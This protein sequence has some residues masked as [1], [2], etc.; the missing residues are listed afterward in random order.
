MNTD[1]IKYSVLLPKRIKKEST[2]D[3]DT[4]EFYEDRERVQAII[5][6]LQESGK[7]FTK[8]DRQG[9]HTY[10]EVL[11]SGYYLGYYHDELKYLMEPKYKQKIISALQAITT[12]QNLA[13]GTKTQ[14][15]IVSSTGK[16]ISN[17]T[18]DSETIG[19]VLQGVG[20][21]LIWGADDSERDELKGSI[22]AFLDP[23]FDMAENGETSTDHVWLTKAMKTYKKWSEPY[24]T[25]A[26]QIAEAYGE[27]AN[28]KKID[29]QDIFAFQVDKPEEIRISLNPQEGQG[30][31]WMLFHEGN[32][33]APIIK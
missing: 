24:F 6:A 21:V 26:Q 7:N 13:L 10:V 18:V 25:A 19:P 27:D 8:D 14:N 1:T 5:D 15:E 20:Y 33:Q 2:K 3:D 30:V 31:T 16:L 17:T 12:N 9:I 32:L 28:G 4:Q 22:D 29:W 11:R 23:I